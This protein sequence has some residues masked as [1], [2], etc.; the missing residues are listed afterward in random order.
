MLKNLEWSSLEYRLKSTDKGR[1]TRERKTEIG[2]RKAASKR[3]QS[4]ACLNYA[5]HEQVQD[6]KVG[7]KLKT[8]FNN[9]NL[10]SNLN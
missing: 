6:D 2:E 1:E 7:L 9:A 4:Q 5:E 8:I 3:E 10:N